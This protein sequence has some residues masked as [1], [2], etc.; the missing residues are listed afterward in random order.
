MN[1]IRIN[2]GIRFRK[3]RRIVYRS[4]NTMSLAIPD[5][6]NHFDALRELVPDGVETFECEHAHARQFMRR[7]VR[8]IRQGVQV[9]PVPVLHQFELPQGRWPA[10]RRVERFGEPV[11][12]VH[13]DLTAPQARARIVDWGRTDRKGFYV[14]DQTEVVVVPVGVA[15]EVID[16]EC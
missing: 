4:R 7:L 13:I 14:T 6:A 10:G 3:I 2:V 12:S 11:T 9:E 8:P 15:H 16:H 1:S 5:S